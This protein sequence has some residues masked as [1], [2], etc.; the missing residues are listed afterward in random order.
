MVYAEKRCCQFQSGMKQTEIISYFVTFRIDNLSLPN[1]IVHRY[2]KNKNRVPEDNIILHRPQSGI[3]ERINPEKGSLSTEKNHIDS[4]DCF[5]EL[6]AYRINY[7]NI[8]YHHRR[9]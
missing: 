8:C 1:N 9:F 3:L 5:V 4:V 2:L 6:Y 7:I